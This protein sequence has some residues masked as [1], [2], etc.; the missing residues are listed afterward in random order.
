MSN[1][2]NGRYNHPYAHPQGYYR[3]A[4]GIS[5][6][7]DANLVAITRVIEDDTRTY[8]L[9]KSFGGEDFAA[10][11]QLRNARERQWVEEKERREM[12][13]QRQLQAA[14]ACQR[15]EEERIRVRVQ[16]EQEANWKRE[17][18]D[19]KV[20]ADLQQA[21]YAAPLVQVQRCVRCGEEARTQ[22]FCQRCCWRRA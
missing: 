1:N 7:I 21:E 6:Y 4:P 11:E 17:A 3:S 5:P 19:R 15:A 14:I 16:M 9:G 12:E 8:D 20:A 2:T 10:R 18:V 22:V 13:A